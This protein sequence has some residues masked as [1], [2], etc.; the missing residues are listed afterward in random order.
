MTMLR[1]TIGNSAILL[2]SQ[3]I[4]W[5]ASLVLTAALGWRLGDAAFGDLYLAMAFGTIFSVLVEF[6][7]NQQLVRAVARDPSLAGPYLLNSLVIKVAF[8]VLSYGLIFALVILLGYPAQLRLTVMIYCLILFW[9]SLAT[10]FT[11]V[12]QATQRLLYP[13]V[14]TIIEKVLVCL[15]ALVLLA[16]GYGIIAMA[17][18]FVAGAAANAIWQGACLGKTMPWT[19]RLDAHLVRTLAV[20]ALPF[21]LYWVLGSIYFRIDTVLL[22]KLAAPAVVGWYGAAYRLFDTLVFL[23]NIVSS[24]ILFPILARLSV[25]SRPALQ[26]AMSK[27]L[28]IIL[29]IGVPL[30]T[31][32]FILAGPIIRF[33][34]RRP[35]FLPAVPALRWLAVALV[36]LYINSLLGVT[37]V[38]LNEERKLTLVA[39]LA[40]VLNL[41]LN[42]LL[43]PHY[44]HIAAAAVTAGTEGFIFCYLFAIMPRDLL[45]RRNLVVLAKTA[46]ATG[47]M[48]VALFALHEL[49]LPL[50]VLVGA[51]VYGT[52]G[53]ALRLAPLEDVRLF[54]QALLARRRPAAEAEVTVA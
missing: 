51:M 48:A 40:T 36:L 53:F 50:L 15:V 25:E 52:A 1:R 2:A 6:G 29:I 47:I 39:G 30:C 54:R 49:R 35:E 33:I 17:A 16:R 7:L 12:Y 13:A 5:T 34:Y 10:S 22:S 23:P 18:V 45:A 46:L 38:S 8:A 11:A 9:N 19:T 20:G 24:A 41:G 3:V 31:G 32:L 4:T 14:G 44:Q 42:W 26:R 37:L 28:D 21:F 27:G 43:I